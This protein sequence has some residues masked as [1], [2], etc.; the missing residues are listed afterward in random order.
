MKEFDIHQEANEVVV[1]AEEEYLESKRDHYGMLAR[2]HQPTGRELMR[3]AELRDEIVAEEK[4][5]SFK[6]EGEDT[7]RD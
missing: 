1:D 5:L 7:G 2:L 3:L 6:N 4:R